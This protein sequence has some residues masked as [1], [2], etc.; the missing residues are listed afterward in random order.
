VWAQLAATPDG[1]P[2][3]KVAG[4]DLGETV[5]LDVDAT[6]VVAHSEKENASATFKKTFGFHPF[7]V[8]CDNTNEFLAA[9]LRTGKAGS[10]T[11]ADHITVL[12]E[13][14]SQIPGS[15]PEQPADPLR[16]CRRL[17]PAPGLAGR[18]RQ[19]S[20]SQAGVQRRLR[21]HREDPGRHQ[22]RARTRVDP[23][24]GC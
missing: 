19:S 13:A 15:P 22:A 23:R 11:A 18:P 5:V 4:T 24:H 12:T 9:M 10:N 20:R 21:G 3:S 2:A 7:G 1:I 8:W 17:A 16:R 6:I 14:I